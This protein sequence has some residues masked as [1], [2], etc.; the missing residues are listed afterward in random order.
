MSAAAGALEVELEK[1]GHYRLGEG[2]RRPEAGDIRR[3]G[4]LLSVS[5]FLGIAVCTAAA[6]LFPKWGLS[7]FAGL[8]QGRRW[9]EKEVRGG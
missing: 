7:G 1:V 9:R 5:V 4:R 6:F 8:Q 3:A 2:L